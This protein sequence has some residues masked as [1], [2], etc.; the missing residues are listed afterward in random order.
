MTQHDLRVDL[1]GPLRVRRG[2]V[3]LDLG[4]AR[5]Q[6]V[7]TVLALQAT[8]R[9]ISRTELIYGVW[10]ENAPASAAG[11][12]H[13]Y[14]SGL[15][16]VLD[17]GR[18]RWS[19][20]GPLVSGPH[21][22]RLALAPGSLDAD[23]FDR[24]LEGGRSAA[25]A[26]DPEAAVAKFDEALALWRGEALAGLPGPCAETHRER[27]AD[28]RLTAIEERAAAAVDTAACADLVPELSAAVREH[29]LREPLW[30][31]L[32]VAL[33]RNGR[34]SEALETFHQARRTLRTELGVNPGLDLMW[35]YHRILDG[36]PVH[37]ARE[38]ERRPA[39]LV[40]V[41]PQPSARTPRLHG[42]RTEIASLHRLVRVLREGQGAAAWLEGEPGIGKTE[43]LSAGLD[44]LDRFPCH[45]V[46]AALGEP[47]AQQPLQRV[48]SA[49]GVSAEAL[50]DHPPE[51]AVEQLLD[52]V[53]ELCAHARL[54][55]VID[56]I[57]LADQA[58]LRLWHRLAAASRRLPLLTIA[59][60]RPVSG[61]DAVTRLRETVAHRVDDV[62]RVTALAESE[63]NDLLGELVGARPGITLRR[64]AAG[65][66]GN[67]RRL[68]ELAA[69][70]LADSTLIVVDG[71]AEVA[72]GTPVP[73]PAEP[74]AGATV[75]VVRELADD[76]RELLRQA[77]MYGQEFDFGSVAEALGKPASHLVPALAEAMDAGLIVEA[78]S[79]LAFS[80]PWVRATVLKGLESEVPAGVK[81]ADP[82]RTVVSRPASSDRRRK[83]CPTSSTGLP[84][85]TRP[86]WSGIPGSATA[87]SD[88]AVPQALR[89]SRRGENAGRFSPE[90]EGCEFSAGTREMRAC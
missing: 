26:G 45:L 78:G 86:L 60:T 6:A 23:E 3:E 77:A 87:E 62:I 8:V 64:L 21:G 31:S 18:A 17:P 66:A 82:A 79:K 27:L 50:S 74:D 1:L 81:P 46:W 11:S 19:T 4:Q 53:D 9:P 34:T 71:L 12:V 30:Q 52:R 75:R 76:T 43:L 40:R 61:R 68:R 42:R 39:P 41:W 14:V 56:D 65:A 20:D 35:A 22:Y 2:D 16:R 25:R 44:G 88:P 15:R 24:A 13:T 49:L 48:A 10:G 38:Q 58:T 67:P 28:R 72:P 32:M 59:V 85:L 90:Q 80:Q 84:I 70:L 57:Q 47:G 37:S 83:P 29:P 33:H 7:F 69:A 5:Q 63:A 73:A 51:A 54:V 89:K 55:L 36:E